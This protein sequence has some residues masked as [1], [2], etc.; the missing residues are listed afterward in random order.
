MRIYIHGL[1][2]IFFF[3]SFDK[4]MRMKGTIRRIEFDEKEKMSLFSFIKTHADA[5]NCVCFYVRV[6]VQVLLGMLINRRKKKK[7]Q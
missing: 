4:W 1:T 5:R 7:K 2:P 3:I 6:C